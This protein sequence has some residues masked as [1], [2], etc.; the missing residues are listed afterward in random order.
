[1]S[2][3]EHTAPHDFLDK[4]PTITLTTTPRLPP[5]WEITSEKI[6]GTNYHYLERII[7]RRRARI[8]W[9]VL[10]EVTYTHN[11]LSAAMMREEDYDDPRLKG[12]LQ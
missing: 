4:E 9:R 11:Q 5:G 1:M 12:F 3:Q 6:D 10:G 7:D 2:E 8:V